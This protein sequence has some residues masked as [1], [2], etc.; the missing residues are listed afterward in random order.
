[1][2]RQEVRP[3]EISARRAAAYLAGSE[4]GQIAKAERVGNHTVRQSLRLFVGKAMRLLSYDA[5]PGSLLPEGWRW[6]LSEAWPQGWY[7]IESED[8][9]RDVAYAARILALPRASIA[10]AIDRALTPKRVRAIDDE[11][12]FRLSLVAARAKTRT[13]MHS[14]RVQ[15]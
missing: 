5:K 4:I 10:D 14:H 12:A 13:W 1:V 6:S 9:Q 2:R 15:S 8:M 11:L 7:V 3:T